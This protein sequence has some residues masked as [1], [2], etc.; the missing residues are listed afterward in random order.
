MCFSQ[1]EKG[2]L[3]AKQIRQSNKKISSITL[4]GYCFHGDQPLGGGAEKKS[5]WLKKEKK[6]NAKAIESDLVT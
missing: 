6:Q 1:R 5:E 3:E 2:S 4:R